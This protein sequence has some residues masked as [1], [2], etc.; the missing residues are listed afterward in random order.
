M[1]AAE[2]VRNIAVLGAF[3]VGY[4]ALRR[5]FARRP[6][7]SGRVAERTALIAW[8]PTL[9][10][11]VQ[12]LAPVLTDEELVDV[13]NRVDTIRAAA[14]SSTRSSSWAL[15]TSIS[16]T[17]SAVDRLARRARVRGDE[18]SVDAFRLQNAI[19]EDVLPALEEL[20]QS[21]QHN[22]MLDS[23]VT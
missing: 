9:M 17:L 13:L 23:L 6:V 11:C 16:S 10:D 21:I 14:Q 20:L 8:N 12:R 2:D 22:H 3:G 4:V 7:F 5:A 1:L 19:V 15:Q 18:T